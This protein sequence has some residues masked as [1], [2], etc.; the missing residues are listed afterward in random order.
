MV[1]LGVPLVVLPTWLLGWR[2]RRL[3][4]KSQD[5]IGDIGAYIDETLHAIRTVQA[6]GHEPIDRRR[7]GARVEDAFARRCSARWPA[8]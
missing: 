4:R 2:V 7:Y 8:R 6:F 3:S 5:R 1:L